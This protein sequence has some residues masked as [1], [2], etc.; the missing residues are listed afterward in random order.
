MT[1][2][3]TPRP[4][5]P[6]LDYLN[7]LEQ[8]ARSGHSDPLEQL[9]LARLTGSNADIAGLVSP[10][11][12]RYE[13][14]ANL[15]F[16][17][18]YQRLDDSEPARRY[19]R[20]AA[21]SLY[22]EKLG[23]STFDLELANALGCLIGFFQVSQH[24]DTARGLRLGL[25]GFMRDHLPR[26]MEEIV[27]LP[28]NDLLCAS[29]ALDLWL[30][31]TPP[32]CADINNNNLVRSQI[33]N[34]F[35]SAK[36]SLPL[37]NEESIGLLLL[38]FRAL[39]LAAPITAGKTGIFDMVGLVE[40]AQKTEHQFRR[41]W[42]GLCYELG[43]SLNRTH[44]AKWKELFSSGLKNADLSQSNVPDLYWTSLER[45]GFPNMQQQTKPAP[46]DNVI[47]FRPRATAA[48]QNTTSNTQFIAAT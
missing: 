27:L 20:R 8:V 43:H 16:Y 12:D 46:S 29:H 4:Y 17:D 23:S 39:L 2:T 19:L 3:G 14:D 13:P 37:R 11:L 9:I 6:P 45:L 32:G 48:N 7:G 44:V 36:E 26:P 28:S 30:A 42:L 1:E 38:I 35:E 18:L 21:V 41:R 31:V 34:L 25:W 22:L 24:E 33:C 5:T 15:L 10:P 40:K 47:E